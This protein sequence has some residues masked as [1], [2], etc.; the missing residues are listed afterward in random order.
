MVREGNMI[1][2]REQFRERTGTLY[3]VRQ[4][5]RKRSA[6]ELSE[7][8]VGEWKFS[9]D[10]PLSNEIDRQRA[11][12]LIVQPAI[13]MVGQCRMVLTCSTQSEP[14]GVAE[15]Q[16]VTP[17]STFL[18]RRVAPGCP[19]CLGSRNWIRQARRRTPFL[20]CHVY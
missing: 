2:L 9:R 11:T 14:S 1:K 16:S 7:L 10:K 17:Q 3:V 5:G 15:T 13:S 6:D 18:T 19:R 4:F 20:R 12:S 8:T